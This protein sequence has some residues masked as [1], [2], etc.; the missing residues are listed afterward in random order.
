VE[1]TVAERKRLAK[2]SHAFN[3]K[4]AI[5]NELFPQLVQ[6]RQRYR[7]ARGE[8]RV[9]V[10]KVPRRGGTA[11]VG[12]GER[13]QL[14]IEGAARAWTSHPGPIRLFLHHVGADR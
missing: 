11:R 6:V 9:W 13:G 3:R 5:F 1:T 8:T 10:R 14:V 2:A 12:S 7:G 4:V